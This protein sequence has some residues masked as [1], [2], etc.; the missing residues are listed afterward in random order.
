MQLNPFLAHATRARFFYPRTHWH[1]LI[2]LRRD[3]ASTLIQKLPTENETLRKRFSNR[4][5]LKTP[6]FVF[7]VDRIH[8]EIEANVFTFFRLRVGQKVFDTFSELKLVFEIS[9]A[10]S[11]YGALNSLLFSQNRRYDKQPRTVHCLRKL[12]WSEKV[13]QYS[14]MLDVN[15]ISFLTLSILKMRNYFPFVTRH[16]SIV[17][18][19]H[20]HYLIRSIDIVT[21]REWILF[22]LS[23][24]NRNIK[25]AFE[26]WCSSKTLSRCLPPNWAIICK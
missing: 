9:Q 17:Q 15:F 21:A 5:N 8:F 2:F 12:R 1:I 13:I 19:Y 14:S 7:K 4:R 16:V 10:Y 26:Y 3:L 6:A 20:L 22:R 24:R 18:Q 25:L 23:S 11:V